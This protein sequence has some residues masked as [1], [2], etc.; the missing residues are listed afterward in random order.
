ME[1]KPIRAVIYTRVSTQG[2]ADKDNGLEGQLKRCRK[3][4][5]EKSYLIVNEYSDSVSGT[6][7]PQNRKS[8]SELLNDGKNGLFDTLVVYSFDRLAREIRIFLD[9]KDQLDSI[10]IKIVSTKENIDT[11]SD[12]GDFMMNIYASIANLELRTIRSRL[13]LGK[14]QKRKE[15]G[16]VGGKLPFGYKVI[17]KEVH[18]DVDKIDVIKQ[19]FC[20]RDKLDMSLNKIAKHLND[21]NIPTPSGKG[22]WHS[23]TINR[24][25][26]NEEKYKGCLLNNNENE[27]CWP[28]IL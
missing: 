10:G 16:Y 23:S 27:I 28:K 15:R 5:Q 11:N 4:C 20:F 8:F 19:I 14:D 7:Q 2:Q 18:L 26:N 24:I 3:M 6:V 12:S 17:N 21:T 22:K 1:D 25:L 9:I 13:M